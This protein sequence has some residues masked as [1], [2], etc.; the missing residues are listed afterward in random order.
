MSPANYLEA[1]EE[2]ASSLI[3]AAKVQR[4]FLNDLLHGNATDLPGGST[5]L[6]VKTEDARSC[7]GFLVTVNDLRDQ[8]GLRSDVVVRV[9]KA[10]LQQTGL[11]CGT[12]L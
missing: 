12:V 6:A 1:S 8:S 2:I 5:T 10:L 4:T 7:E 11:E 9:R 3:Q